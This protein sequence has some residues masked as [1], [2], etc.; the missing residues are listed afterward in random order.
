MDQGVG[1][2]CAFLVFL[3]ATSLVIAVYIFIK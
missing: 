1:S 2:T 3:Y